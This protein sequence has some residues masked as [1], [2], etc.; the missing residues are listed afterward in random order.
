V[1]LKPFRIP[2]TIVI[3]GLVIRVKH[4]PRSGP[5]LEGDDGAWAYDVGTGEATIYIASDLTKMAR[6]RYVLMH[7]MDHMWTDYIHVALS[8]YRDLF[9]TDPEGSSK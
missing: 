2:K 6:Q 9:E 1:K 8:Y 3:P 4:V 5:E 7:E